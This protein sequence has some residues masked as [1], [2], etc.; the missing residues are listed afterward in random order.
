M[1][2]QMAKW[3]ASIDRAE[4]V[5]EYLSHAFH[6]AMSGRKGPVVLALPE[7]MLT[8][9]AVAADTD[10]YQEVVAHPGAADIAA[11]RT[12]LAAAQR[13]LAILG[14]SGWNTSAC[15]DLRS[16]SRRTACPRLALSVS[17]ICS[18]TATRITPA[19]SASASIR[20][21]RSG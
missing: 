14:G 16:S 18:T 15:A 2:G 1:Y 10:P 5:P 20:N 8:Q 6:C 21:W 17:R 19:T 11:L 12:L 4:R 3:V 9:T 7:D 13:P